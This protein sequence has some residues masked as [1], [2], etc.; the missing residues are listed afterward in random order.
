MI[1][2]LLKPWAGSRQYSK[3]ASSQDS[4]TRGLYYLS[5]TL[6]LPLSFN[7][8]ILCALWKTFICVYLFTRKLYVVRSEPMYNPAVVS[9]YYSS[10]VKT[11]SLQCKNIWWYFCCSCPDCYTF[12]P[13]MH[14]SCISLCQA[15]TSQPICMSV[16]LQ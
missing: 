14:H 16:K 13:I 9:F 6:T 8:K 4:W 12:Q 3:P 1:L 11:K 15:I 7:L 5:S 10:H 2:M